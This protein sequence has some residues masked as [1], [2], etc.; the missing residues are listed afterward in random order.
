MEN[1]FSE[2]EFISQGRGPETQARK[3]L[4]FAIGFIFVLAHELA[5]REI[6]DCFRISHFYEAIV[7]KWKA[8][9]GTTLS[10]LFRET[11]TSVKHAFARK[12]MKDKTKT[13]NTFRI[14]K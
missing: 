6:K 7:T 4:V 11:F 14:F 5:M 9:T 12:S 1:I 8:V 2:K 13:A 10:L 3:A